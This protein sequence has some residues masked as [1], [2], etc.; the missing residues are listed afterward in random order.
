MKRKDSS[1]PTLKSCIFL[2]YPI[3]Q[4]PPA[5]L[6]DQ[7]KL[8]STFISPPHSHNSRFDPRVM[9]FI[10]FFSHS[11]IFPFLH[12]PIILHAHHNPSHPLYEMANTKGPATVISSVNAPV[13]GIWL[14]KFK[15]ASPANPWGTVH[16]PFANGVKAVPPVCPPFVN[17]QA[18]APCAVVVNCNV[19]PGVTAS[20]A[21]VSVTAGNGVTAKLDPCGQ[22]EMNGAARE[23][24]LRIP[25][26][27][28]KAEGTADTFDAVRMNVW[29]RD[30]TVTI[31]A[32]T[33]RTALLLIKGA[34]PR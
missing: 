13:A 28:S 5:V 1:C 12:L 3:N 10:N 17:A 4:S 21:V 8:I 33:V 16:A 7:S 20:L 2:R 25:R 14:A 23:N 29:W 22:E 26:G 19:E 32:A 9:L 31:S 15:Y 6:R 18:V 11:H 27:V 24:T 30:S 34:A